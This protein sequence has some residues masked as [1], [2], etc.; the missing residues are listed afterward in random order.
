M[1]ESSG[2][3]IFKITYLQTERIWLIPNLDVMCLFS[4][5]I[6]LA[7]VSATMLTNSGKSGHTCSWSQRKSFQHLNIQCN[8]KWEFVIDDLYYIEVH[9]FYSQFVESIVSIR[10]NVILCQCFFC[11][12]WDNYVILSFHSINIVSHLQIC[13]HTV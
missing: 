6:A 4:C 8:V 9:F 7:K 10:K 2:L 12:Y 3:S 5:L 11:A 1:V 13:N